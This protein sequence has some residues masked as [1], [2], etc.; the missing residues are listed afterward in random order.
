MGILFDLQNNGADE[1][2]NSIL[3]HHQ[4]WLYMGKVARSEATA[5][6]ASKFAISGFS[7][8]LFMELRQYNIKSYL[9]KSGIH[10][11]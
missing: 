3:A 10:R 5:Y 9:C 2:A 6:C 8:S 1:I 11:N 7:E 4:H